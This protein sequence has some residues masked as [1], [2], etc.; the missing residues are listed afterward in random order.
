MRKQK[1]IYRYPLNISEGDRVF[2]RQYAP[3]GYLR[4]CRPG[5][6]TRQGEVCVELNNTKVNVLLEDCY[7]RKITPLH[8]YS[9]Q[10]ENVQ[11]NTPKPQKGTT[12]FLSITL[13]LIIAFLC[14]LLWRR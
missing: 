11:V 4:V 6:Y 12:R 3:Y 2:V 9:E 8:E 10:V 5:I 1:K 14:G 13:M 7:L